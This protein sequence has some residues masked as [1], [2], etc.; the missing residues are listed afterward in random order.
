MYLAMGT[1]T[2]ELPPSH[3]IPL[4]WNEFPITT[5]LE[6]VALSFKAELRTRQLSLN[7]LPE[8]REERHELIHSLYESGLNDRQI[9]DQLNH[10]GIQTPKG[11]N[12][13]PELVFVTRRKFG[14][15]KMRSADARVVV[16]EIAISLEK[17]Y[18]KKTN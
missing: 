4:Q 3:P 10:L 17:G 7:I 6:S 14:N 8:G 1:T 5:Q 15:R 9:A 16:S 18:P 13:Y 2:S 12:Y 11:L